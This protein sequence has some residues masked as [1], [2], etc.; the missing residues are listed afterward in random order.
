MFSFCVC[1]GISGI[2]HI[3]TQLFPFISTCSFSRPLMLPS[4]CISP[5]PSGLH[6]SSREVLTA[7]ILAQWF[8]IQQA[9]H[10]LLQ[11][12]HL[13]WPSIVLFLVVFVWFSQ[14]ILGSLVEWAAAMP[15]LCWSFDSLVSVA[16]VL[17]LANWCSFHLW[18]HKRPQ[19]LESRARNNQMEELEQHLWRL[20]YLLLFGVEIRYQDADSFNLNNDKFFPLHRCCSNRWVSPAASIH[21]WHKFSMY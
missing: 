3:Q 16:Q 17:L 20:N 7:L 2:H 6:G 18:I 8:L 1:F 19:M 10:H 5:F 12:Y 13:L 14:V 4:A 11:R 21:L 15:H 9:I